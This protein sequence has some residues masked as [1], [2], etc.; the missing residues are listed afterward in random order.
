MKVFFTGKN[1]LVV[2][3]K[4]TEG[5]IQKRGKLRVMRDGVQIGEGNIGG[6]KLVNEDVEELS[7]GDECGLR[8]QGKI[9]L[10]EHDVLEAWKEE[11][12]MKTL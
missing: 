2:G 8:Y 5:V 6:L 7:K 4:I 10:Q 11:K 1:E 9:L 3:G 12:K